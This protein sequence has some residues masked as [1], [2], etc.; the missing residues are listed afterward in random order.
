MRKHDY[1]RACLKDIMEQV[2]NNKYIKRRDI[3]D[4][5]AFKNSCGYEF[6]GPSGFYYFFGDSTD[7]LFSTKA[8]GWMKYLEIL[9]GKEL[10]PV[11]KD[12]NEFY[13]LP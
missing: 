7:C 5:Y 2:K 10:N 13:K 3:K 8:E 11:E 1:C 12:R 6:H 9:E 4:S